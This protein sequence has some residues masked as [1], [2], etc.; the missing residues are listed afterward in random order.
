MSAARA[1]PSGYVVRRVGKERDPVLDRLVGASRRF[2]VHALVELDVARAAERIR[3]AAGEVSWTGF[4]IGSVARAVAVHPDVN[5]RRAGRHLVC[6]DR[7][8]IG[9][10]V[11]RGTSDDPMLDITVVPAADRL[12]CAEV[13]SM[14]HEAKV[15]PPPVHEATRAVTTLLRLPAPLRRAGIR[16]LGARP[17]TSAR[18]GPAVGVT[19]LGMFGHAWGW[20]IPVAPLTVIVSVG[21]VVDR[22]AVEAGVVVARPRLPLTLTFDHA[23][24]DGAPAARFVETLRELVETAAAL[25]DGTR[26]QM[27]RKTSM[28]APSALSRSA[29][30]S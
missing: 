14:L 10:T 30:S 6:F 3:S 26:G 16:A 15:G 24:V 12:S 2:Q 5:V 4:V 19:S 25:D 28:V 1:R 13:T 18:F 27:S 20:V 21:S 29:R 22:P 8:D 11:E 7:V 23:V 9:T 17:K